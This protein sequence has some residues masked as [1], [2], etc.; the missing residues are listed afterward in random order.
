MRAT[1]HKYAASMSG[2]V[3]ITPAY[4]TDEDIMVKEDKVEE[5]DDAVALPGQVLCTAARVVVSVR[6][7]WQ[8][9]PTSSL[10]DSCEE[11]MR[12][13]VRRLL[14]QL[15][16]K[17]VSDGSNEPQKHTLVVIPECVWAA[18]F[19]SLLLLLLSLSLS[20]SQ[21]SLTPLTPPAA[22]TPTSF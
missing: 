22:A 11:R 1:F 3:R 8:R 17:N 5:D 6:Q 12:F 21:S 13:F 15:I 18:C 10:A 7:L 2:G 20:L 16:N 19:S 14:P 4:V 9:V